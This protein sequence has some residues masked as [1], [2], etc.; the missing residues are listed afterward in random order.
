MCTQS[1]HTMIRTTAHGFYFLEIFCQ[2]GSC[3]SAAEVPSITSCARCMCS[4]L[5]LSAVFPD[6][7]TCIIFVRQKR[8]TATG[9][10]FLWLIT[11]WHLRFALLALKSQPKSMSSADSRRCKNPC[12]LGRCWSFLH[13]DVWWGSALMGRGLAG[14]SIFFATIKSSLHHFGTS[15]LKN[16]KWNLISTSDHHIQKLEQ[17]CLGHALDRRISHSEVQEALRYGMEIVF[18]RVETRVLARGRRDS[19]RHLWEIFTLLLHIRTLIPAVYLSLYL[20]NNHNNN[21]PTATA[22]T[23][24]TI[25][26]TSAAIVVLP[27]QMVLLLLLHQTTRT[28]QLQTL[29]LDSSP[30]VTVPCFDAL[31]W[32]CF[33]SFFAGAN[34]ACNRNATEFQKRKKCHPCHQ[35]CISCVFFQMFGSTTVSCRALRSFDAVSIGFPQ[36][37]QADCSNSWLGVP[38]LWVRSLVLSWFLRWTRRLQNISNIEK[39]IFLRSS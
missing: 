30:F 11:S 25:A 28:P 27:L 7:R 19:F 29:N 9:V 31:R 34:K 1:T 5:Q 36:L 8:L 26:A 23:T 38:H 3:E 18:Q 16:K 33:Q 35:I 13:R 4:W 2:G 21:H 12:N 39:Q 37:S 24:T 6:V 17:S 22:T 14:S 32:S 15:I 10:G 20:S